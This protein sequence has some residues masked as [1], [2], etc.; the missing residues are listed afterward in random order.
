MFLV[1]RF[2]DVMAPT[3]EAADL[4]LV[5]EIGRVIGS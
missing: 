3:G 1:L 5:G 2:E 4:P